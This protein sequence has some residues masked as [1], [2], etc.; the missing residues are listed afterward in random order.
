MLLLVGIFLYPLP[1]LLIR[2]PHYERW[3]STFFGSAL[4]WGATLQHA[5][6]DVVIFGDSSALYGI[7]PRQLSQS[8]DLKVINLPNVLTSLL[9]LH[10][11][12]LRTYLASNK[13]PRLIVFYFTPWDLDY[14][15]LQAEFPTNEGDQM[16]LRHGSF[17]EI[18]AYYHSHLNEI[19]AFPF[20][21]YRSEGL[22]SIMRLSQP[23]TTP[24]IATRLG[25]L[26][27][28][29]YAT[30]SPNCIYPHQLVDGTPPINTARELIQR[31][32]TP[33]T[34]V[35]VYIAPIPNCRDAAT[36]RGR[37]YASL[38]AQPPRLLSPGLFASDGNYGH[39]EG[40]NYHITTDLLL[41]TLR[42]LLAPGTA[43][44]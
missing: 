29:N 6:A 38:G 2:A 15:S 10:D 5:D 11:R 8:L 3:S 32:T 20:K 21:F 9:V 13:P 40:Q 24:E 14:E 12:S 39:P 26:D 44:Q 22:D 30:L 41:D 37:N 31:Y 1:F 42:P 43:H 16:L 35:L 27:F 36:I 28:G 23:A 34:R 17:R 18:A 4:E 33:Q 7:D 25:H 19:L